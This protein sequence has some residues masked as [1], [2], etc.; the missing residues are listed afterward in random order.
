MLSQEENDLL[1]RVG[2]GTPMGDLLPPTTEPMG[3]F[4]PKANSANDY[5]LDY[6][7]QRTTL[8]SGILNLGMQDQAMQESMGPISDR[9]NKHLGTSDRGSSRSAGAC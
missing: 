9:S 7:A 4:R 1:T 8:F 2:T 5:L 6:E 3:A